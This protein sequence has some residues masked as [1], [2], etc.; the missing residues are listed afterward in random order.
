[1]PLDSAENTQNAP[2]TP[3]FLFRAKNYG[4]GSYTP[5][6]IQRKYPL[7]TQNMRTRPRMPP[8]HGTGREWAPVG[9]AV[10]PRRRSD[11]RVIPPASCSARWRRRDA[12]GV[13]RRLSPR[14]S[15]AGNC[16]VRR[17]RNDRDTTARASPSCGGRVCVV[18]SSRR[19]LRRG[20]NESSPPVAECGRRSAARAQHDALPPLRCA[21]SHAVFTVPRC[22]GHLPTGAA[23]T[24]A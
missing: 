24:A 2:K 12:C 1:M 10:S 14:A 3:L 22:P 19:L 20:G 11:A 7:C 5:K 4:F 21:L 17:G 23:A 13:A 15:G 8:F 9:G 16:R 6:I 18:A